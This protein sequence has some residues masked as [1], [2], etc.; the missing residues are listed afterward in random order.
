MKQ[1]CRGCKR[2]WGRLG[3][4]HK[5]MPPVVHVAGTNG[6]G[7]TI[8]FMRA[9]LEAAGLKVHAYTTP[10]LVEF[11][12]RIYLAGATIKDDFLFEVLE[13]IRVHSEDLRLGFYEATTAAAFLAFSKVPADILLLET[14][15]GGR[16]DATN[17]IEHPVVTV[18]TTIGKDHVEFLGNDLR[19]IALQKLG[20]VKV[21][22][23]CVSALQYDEVAKVIEDYCAVRNVRLLAFGNDF[24]T[25]KLENSFR[26]FAEDF[27]VELPLPS[28]IGDHQLVNAATAITV[29]RQLKLADTTQIMTGLKNTHWPSRLELI[30]R[31]YI[32]ENW[33]FYLDGAHNSAGAFAVASHLDYWQDKPIYLIFG[34][35]KGRKV[36]EFL[37]KFIGKIA[38]LAL[39][40]IA[41][42]P[43]SYEADEMVEVAKELGFE[44][45]THDN[46][47]EAVNHIQTNFPP[48]RI[49]ALGSLFMRGDI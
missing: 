19:D 38:H 2:F 16:L 26:Y 31:D 3:D 20:I 17:I 12:E 35:T 46:L 10:H 47:R 25:E 6:K 5:K 49:L 34:T 14:G 32:G 48:G 9:I 21:G 36:K 15:L 7:S 42:E 41:F 22:S 8:A 39:A 33:K 24:W 13:E 1:V 44:T 37:S 30:K 43:A 18:I 27:E 45:S 29:V 28:L 11:N 40:K 4:P 23:V